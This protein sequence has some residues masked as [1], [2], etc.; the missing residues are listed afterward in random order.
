[1]KSLYLR[2]RPCAVALTVAVLAFPGTASAL[3]LDEALRLAEREAPS[4]A[5]QAASLQA[6]RSAAV[7]AGEL[8][9]PRLAFGLS[10]LPIEGEERW[11]LN[12]ESM[13]MQSIGLMQ[14]VPNRAKRRARVE[15]AEAAVA[16]AGMQEL[17][18]R[19]TVRQQTAQ[20]WIAALAVE[21]KLDLFQQL[22]TENDLFTRAVQARI[23]G[24]IGNSADSVQ[25]RQEAALLAE[26]E[27]QLQQERAA[28][29]AA[30]RRWIGAAASQP[31]SGDWPSWP[32]QASHYQGHL[33]QHPELQ[34][35]DPMAREAQAK[36]REALAEKRPDWAWGVEYQR[37]QAFGDMV[38]LNLSVDL[39]VFA[40]SRQ[41][42]RIAAERARLSAIESE[43]EA[44]LRAHDAEL[45]AELAELQRLERAVERL[46]QTLVP[47][48]EERV[49]LALAD[50]RGG[51]GEL[52]SVVQAREALVQTRLRR[53]DLARDQAQAHARLHFAFGETP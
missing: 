19:Q 16:V 45:E 27:D 22:Y 17:I 50:Y 35:F 43:R 29:R 39:P 53:I 28:A 12:E 42:P 47:L 2:A 5:A 36:V 52:M 34:L 33:Q 38:S 10:N 26:Q 40:A 32:Y 24:G 11:R 46:D 31:L 30:L 13:T 18:T 23:A 37:R 49:R 41:N 8:P 9:D 3:S 48:A 20:A 44:T 15:V 25:P 51:K 4:L 7:P 1:M 21:R 6:A 14:E